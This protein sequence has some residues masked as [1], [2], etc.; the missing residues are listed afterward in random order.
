MLTI[1]RRNLIRD[2]LQTQRVHSQA[3]LQALLEA[4]GISASQPMISRDLRALK[5]AKLEGA[6]QVHEEER[7]TPLAALKSLLRN[8]SPV[9]AF[10]MVR[11]EPGAANAVAR[12]LEAEELPGVVGS[13]AGDDTVL[14]M[15]A[16][17][18]SG[19]RVRRR[20]RELA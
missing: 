15:L 1:E 5:V 4:Q 19:D 17:R 18:A 20:I 11:C 6:Y 8:S 2:L 16:S 12:A 10:E 3:E 9:M 14:V 13:I 7:V